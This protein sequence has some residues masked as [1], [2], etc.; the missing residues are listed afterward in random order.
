MQSAWGKFWRTWCTFWST[1][2]RKFLYLARK[3]LNIIV[4]ASNQFAIMQNDHHPLPCP[5]SSVMV[6][7]YSYI[8]CILLVSSPVK[9][10]R[11]LDLVLWLTSRSDWFSPKGNTIL[12]CEFACCISV[13]ELEIIAIIGGGILAL[14][15]AWCF[16]GAI[17]RCKAQRH[18]RGR[19]RQV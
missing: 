10:S 3:Y 18:R 1:C 4:F 6:V 9:W 8:S 13:G 12:S 15:L 19:F 17:D 2:G 11:N 16:G 5:T 14:I 7:K